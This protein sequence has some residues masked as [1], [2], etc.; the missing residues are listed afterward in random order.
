M[1]DF[2][3]DK[4]IIKESEVRKLLG[5]GLIKTV[6]PDRVN[7][8]IQHL[9]GGSVGVDYIGSF[10]LGYFNLIIPKDKRNLKWITHIIKTMSNLGYFLSTWFREGNSSF[11]KPEKILYD[12]VYILRFEAKFDTEWIPNSRYLYHV[13]NQKYL[14]KIM[15][16]GLVPKSKNKVTNHPDRIYLS[17]DIDSLCEISLQLDIMDFIPKDEQVFMKIDLKNLYIFLRY[18]GQFEGGVYT[19]DNIPPTHLTII[20]NVC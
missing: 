9:T 11:L 20:E 7:K 17:I 18:D 8:R 12:D 6:H 3:L 16:S 10:G 13:T 4:T 14:K 2:R 15:K 19:T 1:K 5:E